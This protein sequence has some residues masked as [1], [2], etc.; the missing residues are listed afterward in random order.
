MKAMVLCAGYGTRLG[1]LTREIPKP[2]LLLEGRPLLEY[3]I[4]NLARH[5]F[6]QIAINLHFMPDLIKDYFGDGSRWN[7][8][9]QY[10]HETQLLGTAGG[11]KKMADFL[12]AEDL[13]LAH[14]GDILTDQDLTRIVE[15]HRS[16]GALAS[17]LVHQRVGSNSV[18]SMDSK[19]RIIDFLER[20]TDEERRAVASPWA[21][22]GVCICSPNFL[23]A[24]PVNTP[25]DIPRDIL[26]KLLSSGRIY[27]FPL[28]GYR[29]AVDS[30]ERLE[31]ARAA[32]SGGRV[33][34]PLKRRH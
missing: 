30:P 15:F 34:L 2:M 5:N 10:S 19:G 29:C 27:G 11:L 7:L 25:S 33:S 22:S 4:I 3:I 32:V 17:V 31:R 24:I 16:K 12:S 23:D 21:Y 6:R 1:N 14:Y 13:F 9:I 18:V 26:P 28:D 8:E 20:P